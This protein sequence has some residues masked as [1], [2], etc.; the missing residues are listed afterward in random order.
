MEAIRQYLLTVTVCG[1]A[2][3]VLQSF[4]QKK[5][6]ISGMIK[7]LTGLVLTVTILSP[8]MKI[9]LGDFFVYWESI[10][11]D[12][13]VIAEDGIAQS[14]SEWKKSIKEKTEAYIL[15]KAATLQQELEAEVHLS[16]A[17]PPVPDSVI[18]KG[19]VSPYAKRL[20]KQ[21]IQVDLGILEE[22]QI[23]M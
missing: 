4:F 22:N 23:W 9:Q 6:A 15:D 5:G 20:L 21:M 12:A 1:I 16:E 8:W 11:K 18:I 14:N 10:S 17:T 7:L 13:Q 3:S 19:N 2:C